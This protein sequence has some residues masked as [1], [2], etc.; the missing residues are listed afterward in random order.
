MENLVPV[1]LTHMF[2]SVPQIIIFGFGGLL[3]VFAGFFAMKSL[4]RMRGNSAYTSYNQ[5][6]VAPVQYGDRGLAPEEVFAHRL[7]NMAEAEQAYELSKLLPKARELGAIARTKFETTPVLGADEVGVLAL[8]EAAVQE[9]NSGF[10]VLVNTSLE[11]V[12]N[13]D[14]LDAT[15]IAS[16]VS[17]T[18]VK[19]KF[20]VVDRFGRLVVAVDHMRNVPLSRQQNINRTV[21]IE[22]LRKAGV[23]YLEIPYQYSAT[24]AR[25]QLL[26]VLRG[27][28]EAHE[29]EP[30][31]G[32]E[33][34]A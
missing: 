24:N 5:A 3:L 26:A 11:N 2:D 25:A 1:S 29:S 22:V 23:W 8:I 14:G 32:D 7:E 6:V 10:R 15:S 33:E 19:L 12:V 18:G 20:A 13:L 17:M 34:V 4:L 27:K 21:V 16:K 30:E 31:N 28:V 9:L